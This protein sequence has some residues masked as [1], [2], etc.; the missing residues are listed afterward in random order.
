MTTGTTIVGARVFDGREVQAEISVRFVGG[1][2]T[3][4]AARDVARNGDEV[5]DGT[6]WMLLPG[7]IRCPHAPAARRAAAGVHLRGDHRAGHVL[8]A[9]PGAPVQGRGRRGPTWPTCAPVGSARP[10]P[11]AIRR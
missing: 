8:P 10:L 5:V 7:L 3:A 9:G 4:C 2:V 11:A 6:G 1:L